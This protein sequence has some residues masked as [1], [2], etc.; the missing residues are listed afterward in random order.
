MTTTEKDLLTQMKD[1]VEFYREAMEMLHFHCNVETMKQPTFEDPRL[2]GTIV[3]YDFE[4]DDGPRIERWR[5]V[6][7]K[8]EGITRV[9][10]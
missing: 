9:S 3:V 8:A 4:R 2:N 10:K 1:A 7:A 6:I 5:D